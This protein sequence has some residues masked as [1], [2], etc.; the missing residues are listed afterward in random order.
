MER[1][2]TT[3]DGRCKPKP[4]QPL[5]R[6]FAFIP[7]YI[8]NTRALCIQ[9]I[10]NA[11]NSPFAHADRRPESRPLRPLRFPYTSLRIS[12]VDPASACLTRFSLCA[13]IPWFLPLLFPEQTRHSCALQADQQPH[14]CH[15][16]A[17]ERTRRNRLASNSH[18][19]FQPP[20]RRVE[21]NSCSLGERQRRVC[22]SDRQRCEVSNRMTG[23]AAFRSKQ[24]TTSRPSSPTHS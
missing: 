6:S 21:T 19:S 23:D 24:N 22:R 17:E 12:K 3:R 14:Q 18:L 11:S 20:K 13:F 2:R 15:S 1:S 16:C 8:F 7:W 10:P 4:T 9:P 5:E